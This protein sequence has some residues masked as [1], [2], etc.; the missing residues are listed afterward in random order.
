M[1][2]KNSKWNPIQIINTT[3][4]LMGENGTKR[5]FRPLKIQSLKYSNNSCVKNERRTALCVNFDIGLVGDILRWRD[6]FKKRV[7]S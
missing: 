5:T 7:F 4:L 6:I 1:L 3:I 2:Q